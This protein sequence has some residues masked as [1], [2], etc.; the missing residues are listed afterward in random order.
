MEM[1]SRVDQWLSEMRDYEKHLA[2]ELQ[3]V[4]Q[5]LHAADGSDARTN[6]TEMLLQ[7]FQDNPGVAYTAAEA[8]AE[9][10]ENG[11]TTDSADP[12][13][14]VRAALTRLKNNNEIESV[15]RGQFQL[16]QDDP[17]GSA[18]PGPPIDDEPP[19]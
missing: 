15:G 5:L 7:L 14:A 4:R 17:W 3:R 12:V 16:R 19:F 6:T 11:W 8:E 18:P 9:I 2:T 1:I 13:N 10:R